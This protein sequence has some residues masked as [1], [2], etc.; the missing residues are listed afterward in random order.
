MHS[1]HLIA[2]KFQ[3]INIAGISIIS[4]IL[5]AGNKA[6][7]AET[8]DGRNLMSH[9]FQAIK[10]SINSFLACRSP[11][12][13][14][15][16]LA[17]FYGLTSASVGGWSRCRSNRRLLTTTRDNDSASA[18]VALACRLRECR[19]EFC[20]EPRLAHGSFTKYYLISLSVSMAKLRRL[21]FLGLDCTNTMN[22][23]SSPSFWRLIQCSCFVYFCRP[24]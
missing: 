7:G 16:A 3:V 9:Y 24:Q 13:A 22:A 2:D 12:A 18:A 11:A 10:N 4:G 17:L 21:T 6:L 14:C 19:R 1:L 8:A 15:R 23:L 5:L 20:P